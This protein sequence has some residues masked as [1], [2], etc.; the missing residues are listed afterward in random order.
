MRVVESEGMDMNEVG[1]EAVRA[2]KEII[3]LILD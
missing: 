3:R 1:M 2:F